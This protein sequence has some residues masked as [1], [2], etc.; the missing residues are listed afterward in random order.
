MVLSVTLTHGNCDTVYVNVLGWR[1][2]SVVCSTKRTPR[3][4][5]AQKICLEE[6]NVVVPATIRDWSDDI[7]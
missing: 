6:T 2:T 4:I 5:F 7:E 3:L 1:P